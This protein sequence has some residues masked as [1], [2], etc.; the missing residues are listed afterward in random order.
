MERFGRQGRQ[1]GLGLVETL[2]LTLLVGG[3]LTAGF[4][5]LVV[6]TPAEQ[7]AEQQRVLEAA[8]A[9]VEAFV[10][11]HHR[12]P[13]ADTDDDGREDCATGTEGSLPWRDLRVEDSGMRERL[14]G[15]AYEVDSGDLLEA[16]D[17][18]DPAEIGTV[19]YRDLDQSSR[20]GTPTQG[21]DFFDYGH[22]T[23]LDFCV[24]LAEL[25]GDPDEPA[26]AI[27]HPGVRDRDGSGSLL[28]GPNARGSGLAPE[29][30]P[31]SADY[32][33]RVRARARG[34]LGVAMD[35]GTLGISIDSLA[36]SSAAVAEVWDQQ[37]WLIANASIAA[38]TN[39]IQ[40]VVGGVKIV[41]AAKGIA[42]AVVE[43][44]AA[45]AALSAA[46]ASCVVIVGCA[47]IPHAAAWVAA[48][49]VSVAA[50]GAAIAANATAIALNAAALGTNLSVAIEMGT[51]LET[52]NSESEIL[53]DLGVDLTDLS[54]MID[55]GEARDSLQD[56]LEDSEETVEDAEKD[57]ADAFD[58][59]QD[60]CSCGSDYNCRVYVDEWNWG[61]DAYLDDD[62]R[63]VISDVRSNTDE[64]DANYGSVDELR[65]RAGENLDDQKQ[66]EDAIEA[67]ENAERS[68]DY[69]DD[70]EAQDAEGAAGD[71]LDEALDEID[72]Q[73]AEKEGELAD[74]SGE[75]RQQL[76]A[77]IDALEDTREQIAS[78]GTGASSEE[79]LAEIDEAIAEIDD[80]IDAVDQR[81]DEAGDDEDLVSQ[82]EER[83]AELESSRADLVSQRNEID[84]DTDALQDQID[85]AESE[86][87]G[88]KS[89]YDAWRDKMIDEAQGTYEEEY[90][91]EEC[92]GS[93]DDEECETVT[94]TRTREYDRRDEMEEAIDDYYQAKNERPDDDPDDADS[95][96]E[97]CFTAD[98]KW[99]EA[100]RAAETARDQREQ[101][102]DAADLFDEPE[103]DLSG[104]D[105]VS[106]WDDTNAILEEADRRGGSR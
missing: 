50:G 30:Q 69:G 89:A 83:R 61:L 59:R 10:A 26:Y 94:K 47:E 57:E 7:A 87:D 68:E 106:L 23:S 91:E 88:S 72:S 13:C 79:Q 45:S 22:V 80:Q 76:E 43:L 101:A 90:E 64:T 67:L 14:S 60:A 35:C 105:G 48:S 37:V 86:L 3:S 29:G 97:A 11:T 1:S 92:T 42:A 39:A 62:I 31:A 104:D 32:D 56:Q 25:G 81:I 53:A 12:L 34:D 18:F 58:E 74:A 40:M 46:I 96:Y 75:E 78:G 27:A 55:S 2:L 20:F 71:E 73:I 63:G 98:R 21:S 15:L 24:G 19:E 95:D 99:R 51:D 16:K 49:A 65:R 103:L 77:E 41:I 85:Q 54:T 66:L 44:G 6:D 17:R 70:D 9:A 4:L 38:V 100:R 102:Q 5:W 36:L 84:P 82:L 28:D 93:G 8:D 52:A 33:D